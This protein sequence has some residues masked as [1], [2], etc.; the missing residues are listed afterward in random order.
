MTATSLN[1]LTST[2]TIHTE[3]LEEFESNGLGF[4]VIPDAENEVALMRYDNDITNLTIPESVEYNGNVYSVTT[5]GWGVF[6]W[7]DV[8]EIVI[9]ASIKMIGEYN[10]SYCQSLK[11]VTIADCAEALELSNTN[12]SDCENLTEIYV[13]R[14]FTFSENIYCLCWNNKLNRIV[15][16]PEVT[17]LPSYIFSHLDNLSLIESLNPEPPVIGESA[18]G[19]HNLTIIVPEESIEA[20]QN[21]W[22]QYAQYITVA[23]DA[24]RLSFETE[25][26]TIYNGQYIKLPLIVEPEDATVVWSSSNPDLVGVDKE[27]NIWYNRWTIGVGEVTITASSLNG[28]TAECK[29]TAKH[30]LTFSENEVSMIPGSTYQIEVTKPEELAESPITWAS[31][32]NE[33][34]V[35]DENGMITAVACGEAEVVAFVTVEGSEDPFEYTLLIQ[36][37][38]LPTAVAAQESEIYVWMDQATPIYLNFEPD[39]EYVN[40]EM[41]WTVAD[42]EIAEVYSY[43]SN[44]YAVR[45]LK[46]GNTTITGETVNGLSVEIEVKV[47]AQ[48]E[49]IIFPTNRLYI[50]PGQSQKLEF[51]TVPEVTNLTFSYTIDNEDIVTVD[52]DGVI[53]AHN[54]G[55][56]EV[57]I[58]Y[59]NP[60]GGQN[61]AWRRVEVCNFPESVKFIGSPDYEG[62]M[63]EWTYFQLE[64]TP[65]EDVCTHIDWTAEDPEIVNI[66]SNDNSF[67]G[68]GLGTTSFRGVAVNGDVLEGTI[69]ING[70]RVLV[71]GEAINSKDVNLGTEFKLD[72]EASSDKLLE[73]LNFYS[74]DHEVATVTEDGI[75]TAVGYGRTY[76]GVS[77]NV[78]ISE[79]EWKT[80]YSYIEI[81]V[82]PDEGIMMN[83]KSVTL[84][85]G[86]WN[87]IS[88]IRAE[89]T[90]L[91]EITWESSDDSVVAITWS[92]IEQAE[93]NYRGPGV[94]IITATDAYGNTAN[95]EVTCYGIVINPSEVS[96]FTDSTF[97]L[98]W[99]AYPE[100]AEI[101]TIYWSTNDPEFI[102]VD[103]NGLITSGVDT[104]L[105]YVYA[106]TD[107]NGYYIETSCEVR[108]KEFI[109]VSEITLNETIL[110]AEEGT[111][112]QLEATV[113][114]VDASIQALRWESSNE[115]VATVDENGLVTILSVGDAVITVYATDGSGVSASCTILGTS[116]INGI[117]SDGSFDVYDMNGIAV[118][119][120]A[121]S[122]DFKQLA[123]GIYLIR[124]GNTVIKIKR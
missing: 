72:V 20:Y 121:T 14:N 88:I 93:L 13:G 97:Q 4:A 48:I 84:A 30:W 117:L 49:Q 69:T 1:G 79:Y 53:T 116:G 45:G 46:G 43:D 104:G 44:N 108:V 106:S 3:S 42:P 119:K 115:E 102:S 31:T 99:K 63:N 103:E 22:E 70:I 32:N 28:L 80:Y 67:I 100:T 83:T 91:S 60:W 24:E 19:Y 85:P 112:V 41:T 118:K 58:W 66:D 95:C 25:D 81:T 29:V 68:R 37:R 38:D 50:A 21:A 96:M 5:I 9:P 54:L 86:N 57:G 77:S 123:P 89:N 107:I 92:N 26:V 35:V 56:T 111:E 23:I 101:G 33:V 78:D 90:E 82:L 15:L 7:K 6:N 59:E 12:F 87:Y 34:V 10:F 65:N 61:V 36:V 40:R 110:S 120:D 105:T 52:E 47:K 27:G 114:P 71:D 94:A 39:N 64:F 16:G 17:S 75:V 109:P 74:D 11:K 113:N 122:D 8:E 62:T 124:K 76:V 73:N 2:C 55:N 51:T 18:F 98:E